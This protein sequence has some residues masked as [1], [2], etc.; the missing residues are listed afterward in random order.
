MPPSG[1]RVKGNAMTDAPNGL[2]YYLGLSDVNQTH[3]DRYRLMGPGLRQ[4]SGVPAS[5]TNH[6]LWKAERL[7]ERREETAMW[8][9][10]FAHAGMIDNPAAEMVAHMESL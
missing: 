2:R 9:Y 7:Y 5:W 6:L 1:E 8:L 3:A 4:L 10:L